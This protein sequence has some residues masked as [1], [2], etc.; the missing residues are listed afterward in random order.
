[1]STMS[2]L[3]K[4]WLLLTFLI[5]ANVSSVFGKFNGVPHPSNI[6]SPKNLTVFGR[7]ISG[8]NCAKDQYA[9]LALIVYG[10]SAYC[11]GSLISNNLV[12]TAAHCCAKM[13]L[14]F[15]Y[16][17][18]VGQ[19]VMPY[20]YY[21]QSS[22][23]RNI[24]IHPQYGATPIDSDICI[25]HL[26][27]RIQINGD[28]KLANVASKEKYKELMESQL[29]DNSLVMG[30]GSQT[31]YAAGKKTRYEMYSSDKRRNPHVQCVNVKALDTD[32]CRFVF[33]GI[34]TDTSFCASDPTNSGRDACQGDSGG[35]MFCNQ[36][37]IGIVSA[38]IGCGQSTP[39]IYSRV[40]IFEDF[41]LDVKRQA[42]VDFIS[43]NFFLLFVCF[44]I[45]KSSE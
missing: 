6:R 24:Y 9:Y 33:K 37:Q 5:Y 29:C 10:G 14:L 26:R 1:M 31:A 35:P 18:R 25:L 2:T 19:S 15:R 44:V 34:I 11:G 27:D 39:G 17:V 40:D 22:G 28:V 32:I 30:F 38:G 3:L 7:I 13:Y 20:G 21:K 43:C 16:S 8:Y 23:I 42:S 4:C 36:T 12:L 41:I 45:I